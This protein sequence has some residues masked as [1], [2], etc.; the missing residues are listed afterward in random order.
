ML[1]AQNPLKQGLKQ[2]K[3]CMT[4]YEADL[5]AQNPLK[6]GLKHRLFHEHIR[7]RKSSRPESIKTRIETMSW[8]TAADQ[9][10]KLR[11]QN[12]LKQGLKLVSNYSLNFHILLRAQNPLKQGLKPRG[13]LTDY[14]CLL[15]SRPESIKTRIETLQRVL[16]MLTGTSFAP[17]IH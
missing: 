9:Y 2:E 4:E 6:Q 12:P 15:S 7:C 11:A 16:T 10:R 1:R 8:A 3:F 14:P 13:N 17:R 5:R